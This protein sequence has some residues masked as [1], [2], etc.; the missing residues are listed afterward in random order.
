MFSKLVNR[1]I[2]RLGVTPEWNAVDRQPAAALIVA[3]L[4]T[5]CWTQEVTGFYVI[6]CTYTKRCK[7]IQR[8]SIATARQRIHW[9]HVAGGA[10]MR[11]CHS[12]W[13]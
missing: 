1:V 9:L 5:S 6:T 4:P 7:V 13:P 12:C 8:N 3:A 11:W 10:L 2:R